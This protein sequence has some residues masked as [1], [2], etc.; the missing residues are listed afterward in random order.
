MPKANTPK[1][2]PEER[3]KKPRN[4]FIIF[5]AEK[6]PDIKNLGAIG[7]GV[8]ECVVEKTR[9]EIGEK[10]RSKQNLEGKKGGKKEYVPQNLPLYHAPQEAWARANLANINSLMGVWWNHLKNTNSEQVKHYTSLAATKKDEHRIAHPG[11]KETRKQRTIKTQGDSTTRA[12]VRHTREMSMGSSSRVASEA[13]FLRAVS[14]TPSVATEWHAGGVDL[15]GMSQSRAS[16]INFPVPEIPYIVPRWRSNFATGS[17]MEQ[18]MPVN[19]S[20]PIDHNAWT[21]MAYD[22]QALCLDGGRSAEGPW[23]SSALPSQFPVP[24]EAR[25]VYGADF[26]GAAPQT[27]GLTFSQP[28][29]V[30]NDY[31]GQT[32]ESS[33]E[34]EVNEPMAL[35]DHAFQPWA[36]QEG[37]QAW[38]PNG[39]PDGSTVQG[40]GCDLLLAPGPS[41][42]PELASNQKIPESWNDQRF[43]PVFEHHA[44]PDVTLQPHFGFANGQNKFSSD[45]AVPETFKM[46]PS[47]V[48]EVDRCWEGDHHAI[49]QMMQEVQSG[50]LDLCNS[51]N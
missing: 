37:R 10:Q 7:A 39:C 43:F 18:N 46:T 51:L 29:V 41:R 23:N 47:G 1:N 19:P 15:T 26:I 48:I 3:I 6:S 13:T 28:Q 17:S 42:A 5:M 11:H 16:S 22:P 49:V 32:Y 31:G 25:N 8:P 34:R 4:A 27:N 20:Q 12:Q 30:F 9:T 44:R 21:A 14:Q 50:G 2:P 35:S 24:F 38:L 33:W 36:L 45:L 40:D